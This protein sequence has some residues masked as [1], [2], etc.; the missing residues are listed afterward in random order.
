MFPIDKDAIE[1]DVRTRRAYQWVSGA[2]F[3]KCAN[4]DKKCDKCIKLNGKQTQYK[5]IDESGSVT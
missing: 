1:R 4:R 3:K 2:C 5:P